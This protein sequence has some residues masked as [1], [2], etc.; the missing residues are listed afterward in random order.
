MIEVHVKS[1]WEGKVAVR[2]HF[3]SEA[4]KNQEGITIIHDGSAM[5]IPYAE[6]GDRICAVSKKMFRDNFRKYPGE[7]LIYF[8][9]KPDVV[10]SKMGV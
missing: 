4:M 7:R 5:T 6:M 10:Q 9:W 8:K 1:Q 3:V 2:M